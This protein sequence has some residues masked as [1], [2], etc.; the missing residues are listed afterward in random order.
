MRLALRRPCDATAPAAATSQGLSLG[1]VPLGQGDGLDLGEL[2]REGA[3]EEAAVGA[4]ERLHLRRRASR[5]VTRAVARRAAAAGAW[6][7]ERETR[8]AAAKASPAPV[9]SI[10][11]PTGS[12]AIR[13]SRPSASTSDPRAPSVT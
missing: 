13:E 10:G 5:P 7:E 4:D 6:P 11:P 2:G 3:P 9:G 8:Y 12:A 1:H